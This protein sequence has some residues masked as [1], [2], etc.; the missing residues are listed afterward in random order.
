MK[1]LIEPAAANTKGTEA[2][3]T[4]EP[5]KPLQRGEQRMCSQFLI[6]SVG[7]PLEIAER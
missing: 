2:R 4:G 5:L 6:I 3:E 1:T 7:E